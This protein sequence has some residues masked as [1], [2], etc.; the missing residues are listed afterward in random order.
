M[1]HFV[2]DYDSIMVFVVSCIIVFI[3]S[4]WGFYWKHKWRVLQ[5][6]KSV[7]KHQIFASNGLFS[8]YFIELT[9]KFDKQAGAE[10]SVPIERKDFFVL[11][12]QPS[13]YPSTQ[14]TLDFYWKSLRADYKLLS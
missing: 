8:Y 5:T 14:P 3:F 10:G 6:C 13:V 12:T 11:S 2:P 9:Y 4:G 7:A 1:I